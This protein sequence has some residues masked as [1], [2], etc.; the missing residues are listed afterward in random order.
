MRPQEGGGSGV[1][2]SRG[3]GRETEDA[4][5]LGGTKTAGQRGA[6]ARGEDDDARGRGEEGEE[7][8]GAEGGEGEG[9]GGGE[10]AVAQEPGEEGLAA[11]VP[12]K[13]GLGQQKVGEDFSCFARRL[14][15]GYF[16]RFSLEPSNGVFFADLACA[17]P[18]SS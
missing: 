2:R 6:A 11:L 16:E 8:R 12:Q 3:K 18:A 7:G 10:T 9:E 15:N 4:A 17:L 14:T 13:V 5:R 1:E